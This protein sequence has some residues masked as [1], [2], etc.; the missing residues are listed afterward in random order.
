MFWGMLLL[1]VALCALTSSFGADWIF[2]GGWMLKFWPVVLILL[3]VGIVLRLHPAKTLCYSLAGMVAGV[4]LYA[5]FGVTKQFADK[6]TTVPAA[7]A[8]PTQQ[9]SQPYDKTIKEAEFRFSGGACSVSLGDTT[10]ELIAAA[11]ESSI[12]DYRFENEIA[13]DSSS[14][15]FLT[16]NDSHIKAT[17]FSA[18]NK[19]QVSLNTLPVWDMNFE[20]GAAA[21]RLDLRK[22]KVRSLDISSGASKIQI[23]LGSRF[24]S[25]EVR[26]DGGALSAEIEVPETV[27]CKIIGDDGPNSFNFDGFDSI[28]QSEWQTPDFE[29]AQHKI[30][31]YLETGLSS[32]SIRRIGH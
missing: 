13:D 15:T 20:F 2:S 32:V 17:N 12:G 3:G 5:G 6:V 23:Q 22:Y 18:K 19:A 25:A 10:R 26:L 31:I 1:S 16:M 21:V 11:V 29:N 9:F 24:D 7:I 27:G 28:D 8:A 30:V 4:S 14:S